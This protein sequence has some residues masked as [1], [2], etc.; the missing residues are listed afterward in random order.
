MF[1]KRTNTG[2]CSGNSTA[3]TEVNK[4]PPESLSEKWNK[5][6]N[7]VH[8]AVYSVAAVVGFI[9]L[10]LALFYCVSQRRQ[11]RLERQAF[12]T[13]YNAEVLQMEDYKKNRSKSDLG[14][15]SKGYARLN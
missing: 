7:G 3:S 6:P 15:G 12:D 14:L 1:L 13:Q 2:Q 10:A 4:S 8:I 9:I 11:G 5:L